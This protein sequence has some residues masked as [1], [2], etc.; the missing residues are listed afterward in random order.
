MSSATIAQAHVEKYVIFDHSKRYEE[1]AEKRPAYKPDLNADGCREC[2]CG[3]ETY[4][5]KNDSIE[6]CPV[7]DTEEDTEDT[8]EGDNCS[9]CGVIV[10]NNGDG[11]DCDCRDEYEVLNDFDKK[12]EDCNKIVKNFY[13][14]NPFGQGNRNCSDCSTDE[15]EDDE[16]LEDL[17]TCG[18]TGREFDKENPVE[19]CGKKIREDDENIMLGNISYCGE[20]G[21]KGM[22]EYPEL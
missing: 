2:E 11:I 16:D 18:E 4:W 7:C 15:D 17:D 22:E 19:G 8:E 20:C 3:E 10:S 12:C 9:S 13:L 21:E 14:N 6:L 5:S 1:M